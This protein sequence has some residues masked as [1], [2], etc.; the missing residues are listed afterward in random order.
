[1]KVLD[2]LN[3]GVGFTDTKDNESLL[4]LYSG[5]KSLEIATSL[6]DLLNDYLKSYI[7]KNKIN[8]IDSEFY[9]TCLNLIIY[10]LSN[11]DAFVLFDCDDYFENL[12]EPSELY[13]LIELFLPSFK[14]FN[15]YEEK[16]IYISPENEGQIYFIN[17]KNPIERIH[18]ET[19]SKMLQDLLRE[20]MSDCEAHLKQSIRDNFEK[21]SFYKVFDVSIK[22]EEE[23]E[24]VNRLL[25]SVLDYKYT[26]PY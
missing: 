22:D 24:R 2:E 9:D 26:N 11:D 12:N 4:E 14:D 13:E 17:S 20:K 21:E 16:E 1:M 19:L 25:S 18:W 7:A 10:N 15:F 6:I 3:E 5:E 23:L 8:K